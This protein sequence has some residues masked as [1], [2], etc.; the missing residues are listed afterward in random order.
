MLSHLGLSIDT[1]RRLSGQGLKVLKQNYR[2]NSIKLVILLRNAA[3]ITVNID[4]SH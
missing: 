1:M 4:L 3:P 2:M